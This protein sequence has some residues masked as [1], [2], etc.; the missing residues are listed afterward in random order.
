MPTTRQ[1]KSIEE[2]TRDYR[3]R[4]QRHAT[5]PPPSPEQKIRDRAERLAKRLERTETSLERSD[6]R[7]L[8]DLLAYARAQADLGDLAAVYGACIEVCQMA[9]TRLLGI[10]EAHP[11]APVARTPTLPPGVLPVE[12]ADSEEP[13]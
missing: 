12:S 13:P 7:R 6:R 4:L 8:A 1:T 10:R 5:E 11:L 9:R 3:E 2:R